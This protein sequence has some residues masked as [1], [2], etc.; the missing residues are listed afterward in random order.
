MRVNHRGQYPSF[1]PSFADGILTAH[2]MDGFYNKLWVRAS[3]TASGH[4]DL[5]HNRDNQHTLNQSGL[6][7][8]R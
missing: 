7:E 5:V 8:N 1:V 2:T 4:I 3:H 6:V